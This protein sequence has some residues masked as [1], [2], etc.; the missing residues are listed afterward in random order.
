V[1]ENILTQKLQRAKELGLNPD[2]LDPDLIRRAITN[3][4]SIYEEGQYFEAYIED[5]SDVGAYADDD[6]LF[7]HFDIP[8]SKNPD[9]NVQNLKKAL[10]NTGDFQLI[11]DDEELR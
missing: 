9:E 8:K 4:S 2:R 3:D 5:D 6:N 7:L 10:S 11:P 1:P